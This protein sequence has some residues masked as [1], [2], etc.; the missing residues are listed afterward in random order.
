[1]AHM[2]DIFVRLDDDGSHRSDQVDL[3]I[4]QTK[5]NSFT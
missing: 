3:H 5:E 4:R 1:M 2:V